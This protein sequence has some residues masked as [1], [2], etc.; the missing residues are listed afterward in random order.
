VAASIRIKS[1]IT[2]LNINPRF[3]RLENGQY[4]SSDYSTA[5]NRVDM[6]IDAGV[7]SIEIS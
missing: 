1:G 3:S 4:Q 7:G 2:S 6:T 5:S